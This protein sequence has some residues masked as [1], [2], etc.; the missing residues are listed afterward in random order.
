MTILKEFVAADGKKKVQIFQRNDG[1]FGFESL[2]FSDDP[3]EMCW[4]PDGRFSVCIAESQ[5][6]A[7]RE[8]RGRVEWMHDGGDADPT[9]P[10]LDD[11]WCVDFEVI[12]GI[13]NVQKIA[14]NTSIRD[15]ARLRK[16]YGKG[17]W[18]KLKGFPKSGCRAETFETLNCTGMKRTVSANEK[19]DWN[20]T[21]IEHMKKR[22]RKERFVIC[23]D[24]SDYPASLELHKVYTVLPDEKAAEDD[25]I[26]VVDESGE[27]YLYSAKRFV[28]VELPQQ[29]QQAIMRKVRETTML[30]N[31]TLKPTSGAKSSKSKRVKTPRR[32]RL[33]V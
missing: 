5:E 4:F 2:R 17:R 6:I 9:V 8:A 24:N 26:R 15:V 22:S 7:E 18:R 11:H 28:P 29:V 1:S 13:D 20:A 12:G 21:S 16:L 25:F 23:I 33:S 27:D 32:S 10:D 31:T 14:V 19:S 30:A 3:M